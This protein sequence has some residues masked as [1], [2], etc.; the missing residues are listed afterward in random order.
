VLI[1]Q[2]V[3]ADASAVV[4]SANPITRSNSEGFSA[5]MERWACPF[6]AQCRAI[7][8]YG[9]F[10]IKPFHLGAETMQERVVRYQEPLRQVLPRMGEL[11]EQT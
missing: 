6:G 3:P 1:Q 5:A 8:Y 7:N 9:F 11:W 4:F 2:L 10:T